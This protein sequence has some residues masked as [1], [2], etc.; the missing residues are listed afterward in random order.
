MAQ[1]ASPL[2]I[3]AAAG[4]TPLTLAQEVRRSGREVYI[5]ALKSIADADYADYPHDVIRLG[6]VA[7]IMDHF[8]KAGCQDIVLA[9]TLARPTLSAIMPD[10][11]GAKLIGKVMAAGDDEAL[12][13]LRAEFAKDG[14]T[15]VDIADFLAHDYATKGVM[16]GVDPDE[17]VMAAFDIG[18]QYLK[19][20][21]Q[22]DVGQS[23][24]VQ[25]HRII[26]VEAAEGTD[27]MLSRAADLADPD[28]KPL[29]MVKM[30]KSG[31]DKAL[32]P[33][34]F[35]AETVTNAAAS[36]ITFIAIEAGGVMLIDKENTLAT[37]N[38][39]GV[40]IVGIEGS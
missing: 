27:A 33:P 36:G 28:L 40:S 8:I 37:A 10:V 4:V 21:G 5:I 24:V 9:G 2:G 32:D 25:G 7:S 38:A 6:A 14:L 29:V 19:A 39:I 1:S 18:I 31:Q 23:C 15:I 12:K 13:I 35:G 3:I 26:A 11:R 16:A 17:Q 22:F 30:L 20:A 34:G